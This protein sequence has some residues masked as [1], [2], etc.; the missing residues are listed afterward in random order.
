ML[1]PIDA[2]RVQ[3]GVDDLFDL[4]RKFPADAG[5]VMV[6]AKQ[7]VAQSLLARQLVVLTG[8]PFDRSAQGDPVGQVE[9]DPDRYADGPRLHA[10]CRK[11]RPVGEHGRTGY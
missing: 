2:S 5:E 10:G 9:M 6:V 3:S 8:Q 11:G 4:S 7:V 1:M